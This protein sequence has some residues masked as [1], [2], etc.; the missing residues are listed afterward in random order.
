MRAL[1]RHM[2]MGRLRGGGLA[3]ARRDREAMGGLRSYDGR[4]VSARVS[5]WTHC[6]VLIAGQSE[7]TIVMARELSV[8]GL[9]HTHEATPTAFLA[10]SCIRRARDYDISDISDFGS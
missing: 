3:S 8:H 1:V 2:A 10:S 9:E 5:E 7:E 6:C 4:G